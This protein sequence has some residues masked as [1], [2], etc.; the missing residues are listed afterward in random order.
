MGDMNENVMLRERI[1]AMSNE[2]KRIVASVIPTDIL[3]EAVSNELNRLR[4]FEDRVM[5]AVT[6]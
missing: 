3:L 4:N 1:E 6:E 2:E 5:M